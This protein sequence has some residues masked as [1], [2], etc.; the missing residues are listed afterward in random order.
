MHWELWALNSGNLIATPDTEDEAL[1]LVREL[2]SKGWRTEDL[3][4]GVEDEGLPPEVLPPPLEGDALLA[5]ARQAPH[6]RSA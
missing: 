3:S 2:V 4:L 6:R 5:R 1:Q